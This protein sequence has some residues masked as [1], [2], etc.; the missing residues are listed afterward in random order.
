LGTLGYEPDFG[1]QADYILLCFAFLVWEIDN[2]GV[3]GLVA[4]SCPTLATPWTVAHWLLCHPR[5]DDWS[6]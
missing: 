4:K 6:G 1:P 2:S 5:R 3:S